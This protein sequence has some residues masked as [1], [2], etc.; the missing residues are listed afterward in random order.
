MTSKPKI[1]DLGVPVK[2]VNWVRLV[3]GVDKDDKPAVYATMGQQAEPMFLLQI[4]PRTGHFAQFGADVPGAKFPT[5]CKWSESE[6]CFY[7]GSAY[8][9]HLHRFDP[10][11]GVFEDLGAI[12]PDGGTFPCR[13][14]E[15]PD[16]TL[17]IG[18]YGNCG[19]TRFDPRSGEFTRFGRMDDVD[20]YFY[21]QVGD[22][23]TVAGLVKMTRQHV[24]VIDPATGEH[25]PVGP[26]IDTDS[27]IG[28][29][30]LVKGADGRLYIVSSEGN[31]RIGGMEIEAVEAAPQAKPASVLPDGSTFRFA[32]A[33]SFT[34]REL[35]ITSPDGKSRTFNLDWQGAGTDV[36]LVH[37]GPD[38]HVYGSSILPERLFRCD[39]ETGELAD[40]GQC[41]AS[42]GE[43]YSMGNLDGLLYIASYPAARLSIYDPSRPYRFG[44]D[45][46]ANPRDVGRMDSVSYRP[47]VMLAGPAGRI[48]TGSMPDYGMW[49]GPLAWYD[50]KTGER[51]SCRHV[52]KNHSVCS[53]AW[54]E[55]MGLIAGG[56]TI[57]A[58]TG[59]Q[60]RAETA[61][62]F[63]WDPAGDCKTWDCD[64]GLAI[65][66]VTDLLAYEGATAYAIV[67]LADDGG[68][69]EL[70][71][72]DFD[73][74]KILSRSVMSKRDGSGDPIALSM[75]RTPEGRIFGATR[76]SLFEVE[77]G[78]TEVRT[79]ADGI[80]VSA[81]GPVV[82]NTFYFALG[83][84]LKA[85]TIPS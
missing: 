32:D 45:D 7:V 12:D 70:M 72:V 41:S 3:A 9:G 61:A 73:A 85:L 76:N 42:G 64:F 79:L 26:V 4:D 40:L 1:R 27:G 48:W 83:H 31:F 23:G 44:T 5:A 14:D 16:G 62:F 10:K 8:A 30:D 53:L 15:A 84:S 37:L 13:I 63:L 69:C 57:G 18:C 52:L 19:L 2:S 56:T 36:F 33:K 22:D 24:V 49:G 54:I 65:K 74:G 60:P 67:N 58:G 11:R 75:R 38:G 34:H 59:T 29:I 28:D 81:A 47:V 20:M 78:T 68:K 43:A 82:G 71:L 80:E 51:G 39:V 46:D 77:P 50:P 55:P 25:R 35:E 6:K 17:W 66:S 21:P